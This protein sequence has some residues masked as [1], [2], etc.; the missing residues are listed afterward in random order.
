MFIFST[1]QKKQLLVLGLLLLI[2]MIFEMA[3]L[4]VLIPALGIML[5]P[6]IVENYPSLKPII[7][8]LGNPSSDKLV[9]YGLI[10]MVIVYTSKIF[11]LS[12]LSWKQSKFSSTLGAELSYS[13]FKGYILQPYSFHLNRN[14]SLLI[15]NI[16]TE[17]GQ[18]TT[19][20]QSIIFLTIESTVILGSAFM[21]IFVDPVGAISISIFLLVSSIIFHRLTKNKLL[22]WGV[23]R[24]KYDSEI[25]QHLIQGLNAVKDVKIYGT[26]K[27]F[28]TKF[29]IPNFNKSKVF[30]NQV[31][32][33]QIPRLYL[34]LLSIMGLVGLIVIKMLQHKPLDLLLPTLGVFVAA[35]FRMLPSVNRIMSSIQGVKFAKPVVDVLYNEFKIIRNVKNTSKFNEEKISFI[36]SIDVSDICFKYEG[37]KKYA[38]SNISFNIKQGE[39]IGILGPSGSGKSTLVDLILGLLEETSGEITVDGVNINTCMRQWQ[40]QI[41]YVPQTIYLLDDSILHNIAFGIPNDKIDFQAVEKALIAAQ[42]EDYI[43]HLPDGIN[44][45]VGERGVRLSGGQRQRIGIARAL[46]HDPSILVLDEATSALD[47]ETEKEVMK[48]VSAFQGEKTLIIIAHRLSTLNNCDKL[49]Q[50]EKGKIVSVNSITS[51]SIIN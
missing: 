49:Y 10:L 51:R 5:N 12:F 47:Y 38:L 35:A 24:Q 18:F 50:L 8:L 17:I 9:L 36:N 1:K 34:E 30:T 14:S 31:T 7:N 13:L 48:S 44:T 19:L 2:G 46:Y 41:G 43:K 26:E 15:K 20:S 33:Q 28:L 45:Y 25:N 6:H 29:N 3:G 42:L 23:L 16:Q 37:N 32:L 22:S 11:F 21:L 27:Y 40:D 39:S 4:G